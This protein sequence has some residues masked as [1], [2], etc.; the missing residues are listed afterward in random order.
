MYP[1][2]EKW[3]AETEL[4]VRNQSYVRIVFGVTDPNALSLSNPIDNGHLPYS[5]V[6]SVDLGTSVPST[7]QTLERNR[8]IL[9]GKNPLPSFSNP[10]YQGYCGNLIS[11]DDCTWNINPTVTITFDDYVEFAGLTFEFDES[12][13][14]YPSEFRIQA[15]Y[16]NT[17]VLDETVMPDT[18]FYSYTN[19][20]PIHN[21]LVF[22]W[23]KSNYP[24]R[25]ARL[26]ALTYGLINRLTSSDIVSCTST[27]SIDILSSAIPKQEFT[28]TFIDTSKSYDPENPDSLWEYLESRQPV[29]YYYGYELSDGSVEYIPWGLSYTTGDFEVSNQGKVAQVTIKAVGLADHLTT[30][31]DEGVYSAS[32]KSLYDL[33]NDVMTFA[34]FENTIYLDEALKEIKTHKPLPKTSCRECLQLIANAGRCIMN[35]SR[36]GYISIEREANVNTGFE[37]TFSKMMDSPQTSK[38]APLRNLNVKYS[39]LTVDSD[40]STA[41]NAAAVN[42]ANGEEYTFTYDRYT[43]L[44]AS[45]TGTL[46]ITSIKYYAYKTVAVLTGTGTITI[47]GNKLTENTIEYNKKYSDV[48]ED[49]SGVENKLLDNIDDTMAYA[50]WT[51]NVTLRRSSYSAP[52]R[53]YPEID[54]GDVINFTS[55]FKNNVPVTVVSQKLT[56]DGGIS[57][58]SEYIIQGG[59]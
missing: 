26:T 18:A 13:G 33:A 32:G 12:M 11:N 24:H 19:Q 48:G 16:G 25:R 20:I 56:F 2:T 27:K 34:G 46:S 38:I 35:H 43:N 15:Y 57:G 47:S 51:A 54:C 41:V 10:V 36:G 28:F 52:D 40:T 8:F 59:E 29:T 31:Y 55:N 50:D 5:T 44:S 23:I 37:M 4:R 1:V 45:V 9:D 30:E 42:G 7:Y 21:K 14:E 49:L 3:Q 17:V 53:G 39:Y 22:T 6:A 58:E